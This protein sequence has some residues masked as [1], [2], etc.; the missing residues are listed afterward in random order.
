M[1]SDNLPVALV[2]GGSAGL[3]WMIARTF[4]QN[5]YR[6]MIVGRDQQRLDD[7]SNRLQAEG[8]SSQCI[9]TIA[10]NLTKTSEATRVV[11][12]VNQQ[13]QQLDVLVNCVGKSDRGF[14]HQL[15][16]DTLH[17][18]F[19]QNVTTAL[20]CSQAAIPLLE[21]SK[22]AIVN[23]GSLASKVGARYIG[24]YSAAKHALAGMTQQMR[25]ELRPKGIH[26]GLVSPGP[27]KRDDAGQRYVEKLSNDLPEQASK[28]GAGT[29]V[30]GL[31]PERVAKAV[32]DCARKRKP[33][34]VLP[35]HMRVLIA[36]GH[37]FP[38]LGDW[39]LLKFTSGG[40]H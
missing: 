1:S 24:G 20:L 22:G 3:G 8:I 32:L 5:G 27:I 28:P 13:F 35:G 6:V 23:I 4:L 29:R 16:A 36:L 33:D 34:V 14:V 30:K 21:S 11:E 9:A 7:A 12:S 38:R 26:V 37:A 25:L 18:L 19:Q 17:N 39:L 15:D 10:A 31:S 40:D 2:T